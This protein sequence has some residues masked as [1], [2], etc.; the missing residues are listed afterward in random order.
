[1]AKKTTF[2]PHILDMTA[3]AF[4]KKHE[5]HPEKD[6]LK[7]DW[8]VHKKVEKAKADKA[9]KSKDEKAK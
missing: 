7:K 4:D 1:M 5:K 9:D 6:R 2:A 8:G 3:E